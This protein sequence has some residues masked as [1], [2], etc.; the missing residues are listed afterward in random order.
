MHGQ[1]VS[2]RFIDLNDPCAEA[3]LL[4]GVDE[5][6]RG[7]LAGPVVVAAVIMPLDNIIEGVDDSKKLTPKK[8]EELF[9]LIT[10]RAKGYPQWHS[11]S[12][13]SSGSR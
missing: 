7:P 11:P 12:D 8:R 1:G 4:A 3:G 6:G 13:P 9:P 2:K 5:A 10:E